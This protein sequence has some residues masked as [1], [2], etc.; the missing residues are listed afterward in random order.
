[1]S[2]IFSLIKKQQKLIVIIL[3][4]VAIITIFICLR[5]YSGN[6]KAYIQNKLKTNNW[7]I[8]SFYYYDYYMDEYIGDGLI[9]MFGKNEVDLPYFHNEDLKSVEEAFAS[10]K[11]TWDIFCA[12]PD[13]IIINAPTNPLNGKYAI[14]LYKSLVDNILYTKME[15]SNDSIYILCHTGG[16]ILPIR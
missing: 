11:G 15:L 14:R 3:L 7:Q 2:F 13:S 12:N 1:M 6:K 4:I 5:N 10:R 9:F 8:E 16:I